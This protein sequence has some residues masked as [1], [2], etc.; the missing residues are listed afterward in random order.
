MDTAGVEYKSLPREHL[1]LQ[2]VAELEYPSDPESYA[3]CSLAMTGLP[4][5]DMLKERGQTKKYSRRGSQR[6]KGRR[7]RPSVRVVGGRRSP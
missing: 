2:L 4:M 3:N 7:R 1:T 5:L 6:Q